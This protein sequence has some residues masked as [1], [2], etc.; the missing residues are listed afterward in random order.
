MKNY[1]TE[2][3]LF[4]EI[5]ILMVTDRF[6]NREINW[7]YIMTFQIMNEWLRYDTFDIVKVLRNPSSSI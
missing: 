7:V 5:Y 1:D 3:F 4:M 6:K 2:K